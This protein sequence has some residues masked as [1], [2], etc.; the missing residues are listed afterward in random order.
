MPHDKNG[1]ELQAGDEVYLRCRIVNVTSA[2]ERYCNVSAE[3]VERPEGETYIPV[4]ACN[5]KF[6]LKL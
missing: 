4:I 3:P 2:G 5:S 1:V 6:Y